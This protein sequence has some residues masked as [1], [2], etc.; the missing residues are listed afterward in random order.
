MFKAQ[1]ASR[2]R[3]RSTGCTRGPGL[4]LPETVPSE[5]GSHEVGGALDL[6]GGRVAEGRLGEGVKYDQGTL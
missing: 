2:K 5:K 6:R 3:G 1:G 4:L